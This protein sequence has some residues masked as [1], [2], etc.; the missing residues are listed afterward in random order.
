MTKGDLIERLERDYIPGSFGAEIV[1]LHRD[2]TRTFGREIADQMATDCFKAVDDAR[3]KSF[4]I[5]AEKG[6]L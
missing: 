1:K 6:M 4:R 5:M 2:A 3:D